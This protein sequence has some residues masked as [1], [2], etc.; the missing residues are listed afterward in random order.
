MMECNYFYYDSGFH[1]FDHKFA[2]KP[3]PVCMS[4]FCT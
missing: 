2:G 4:H 3:G 1:L